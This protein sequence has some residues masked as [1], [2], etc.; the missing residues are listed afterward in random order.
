MSVRHGRA[1]IRRSGLAGAAALLLTVMLAACGDSGSSDSSGSADSGSGDS[2]ASTD[3]ELVQEAQQTVDQYIQGTEGEPPTDGPAA[4]PD[5]TV[6]VISCGQAVPGCSIQTDA[7]V[8]AAETLG[9]DTTLFDGAF[10]A[11]R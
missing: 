10:G 6:W 4:V 11:N 8:E 3:P 1:G 5:Q 9:W 2:G 7:A